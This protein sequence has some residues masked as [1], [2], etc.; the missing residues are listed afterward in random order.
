MSASARTV[1]ELRAERERL[2]GALHS[3]DDALRTIIDDANKAL[4]EPIPTQGPAAPT[5]APHGTYKRVRAAI[6]AVLAEAAEPLS[7]RDLHSEV[8][9]RIP[10]VVIRESMLAETLKH[11]VWKRKIQRHGTQR[12]YRYEALRPAPAVEPGGGA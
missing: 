9:R 4:A 12:G 10:G 6:D 11:L 1:A 8:Q 7:A 5:R 3:V 2:L